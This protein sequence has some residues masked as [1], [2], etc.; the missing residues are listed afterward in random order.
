MCTGTTRPGAAWRGLVRQAVLDGI[1]SG[2][3]GSR[4]SPERLATLVIALV[5]GCGIP[6]VLGDPGVTVPNAI[7]DVLAALRVAAALTAPGPATA[8]AAASRNAA[9][10]AR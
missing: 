10:A 8:D 4:L 3:F 5:D 7:H 2:R 6:L 9:A 1:S